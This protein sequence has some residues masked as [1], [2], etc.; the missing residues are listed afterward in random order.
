[1]T[2]IEALKK[3]HAAN[4][5]NPEDLKQVTDMIDAKLYGLFPME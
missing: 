2:T 4:G 3:L 5:D 1:M